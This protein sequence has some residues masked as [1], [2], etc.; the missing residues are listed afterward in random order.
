[1][2]AEEKDRNGNSRNSMVRSFSSFP[3]PAFSHLVERQGILTKGGRKVDLI[4]AA[5]IV[6]KV[7]NM[8][9]KK[10]ANVKEVNRTEPSPSV[11]LPCDSG[12]MV[13]FY[14]PPGY[15][16]F[17]SWQLNESH[18]NGLKLVRIF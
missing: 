8:F 4:K 14:P 6:K 12:A 11:R 18:S 10:G 2:K 13:S 16:V 3:V 7:N 5:C 15:C 17:T 1:M 9:N